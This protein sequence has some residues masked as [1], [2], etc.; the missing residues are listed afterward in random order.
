MWLA[1]LFF[2]ILIVAIAL[3]VVSGGIFTIV[4]LPVVAVIGFGA[5]AVMG[6]ANG[7]ARSSSRG[8]GAPQSGAADAQAGDSAGRTGGT[9]HGVGPAGQPGASNAPSA[10]ATPGEL[11]N[12]RQGR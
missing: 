6:W 5:L 1:L 3:S 8:P 10:P 2:P 9:D 12:A 11:A 7:S 4:V